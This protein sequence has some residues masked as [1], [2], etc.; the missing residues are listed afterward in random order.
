MCLSHVSFPCSRR[1]YSSAITA[2]K[3][4][5]SVLPGF[6]DS[7]STAFRTTLTYTTFLLIKNSFF[8][9]SSNGKEV[10]DIFSFDKNG[11]SSHLTIGIL[12]CSRGAGVTHLALAL[13]SY[14][15]SKRGKSCAYLELHA[16]REIAH[17]SSHGN[18]SYGKQ[19]LSNGGHLRRPLLRLSQTDYYPAVTA[20]EI[21]LLL[22]QG[23]DYL[24]LDSGAL[25]EGLFP[26]FLRCD[27]KFVLGSLAP[28]KS[29]E[30]ESFFQKFTDNIHLGEGFDY[31]VQTGSTKESVSFSK[32]HHI[33]MQTVPFIKNPFRIEKE[34]FPFLGALCA[35]R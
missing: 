22:N 16:R 4:P 1:R 29:W 32:T 12:G 11:H 14:C 27:R 15:S 6:W 19:E 20:D 2:I 9:K 28:W 21:P 35:E 31:L 34:L 33:N 30:Y 13:C 24:I 17:L 3:L 25:D 18:S 8:P 23:Y 7:L 5:Q 26:E 10:L